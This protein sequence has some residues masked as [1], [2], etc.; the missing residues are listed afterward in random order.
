VISIQLSD[1]VDVGDE[2]I[3]SRNW[4]RELDL[5]LAARLAYTNAIVLAESV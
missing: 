4:L 3:V 5:Q 2:V 1:C